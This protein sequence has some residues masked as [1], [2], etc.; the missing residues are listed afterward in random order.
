MNGITFENNDTNETVYISYEYIKADYTVSL[1]MA[2]SIQRF[3]NRVSSFDRGN[4][5][6]FRTV[7]FSL[8]VDE[9]TMKNLESF[10]T[11]NED[12][13]SIT[14]AASCGFYP[15]GPDISLDTYTVSLM[16][17]SY[18]SVKISP[19]GMYEVSI[20]FLLHN[21]PIR[22]PW[23]TY[24]DAYFGNRF[25]VGIVGGLKDP[26]VNPVQDFATVRSL[27][28]NGKKSSVA[29]PASEWTS[30]LKIADNHNRMGA[31]MAYLQ[32]V[33]GDRFELTLHNKLQIFGGTVDINNHSVSVRLLNNIIL[34]TH[35]R[36]DEWET[37]IQV[38]RE[39][40]EPVNLITDNYE[41][42]I[43]DD[44]SRIIVEGK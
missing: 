5:S 8:T 26:D 16:A 30:T 13:F 22:T 32:S 28:M 10:L 6:D 21:L 42:I 9:A 34:F 27:S 35:K 29:R 40:G 36:K 7:N 19:Y 17:N 41:F 33:R 25:G 43:T 39:F 20:T 24:P 11:S 2:L 31:L 3:I 23:N 1:N 14:G 12:K 38:W 4:G 37:T 18:S 15:A 44:A